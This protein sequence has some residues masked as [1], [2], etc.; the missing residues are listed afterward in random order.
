MA[1]LRKGKCYRHMTRPYTRR[2]KVKAKAYIKTVPPSKVVRY[3]MGDPKK[4]YNYELVLI[5]REVG[6]I[7]HNAIESARQ[8][9]NRKLQEGLGQKAYCLKLLLYPHH[10]L[11]ENK[12][13]SGAHADRLQ[14]G[15][16]HSFGRTVGLAV[17]AK[18]G[19]ALFSVKVLT[20]GVEQAR[21]ALKLATPRLPGTYSIQVKKLN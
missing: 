11:R 20:N 5:S 9:V 21:K 4:N 10:I 12:M 13:L 2:S 7:R 14:T 3:D 8:V 19:K 1:T 15:M 17:R 16:A 6:Q 18:K